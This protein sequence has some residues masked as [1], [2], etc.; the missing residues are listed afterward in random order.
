MKGAGLTLSTILCDR[1]VSFLYN[2][3]LMS[4]ECKATPEDVTQDKNIP[5]FKVLSCYS[6]EDLNAT[7]N[8]QI[9][10]IKLLD[11]NRGDADMKAACRR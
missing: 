2:S 6:T 8:R 1:G 7:K 5:V 10:R 11:D 4:E 3:L 9:S